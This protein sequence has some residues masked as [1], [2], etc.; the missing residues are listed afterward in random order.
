[1]K[2][3][4]MNHEKID[5]ELAIIQKRCKIRLIDAIDVRQNIL[6]IENKLTKLL[7]ESKWKG[8]K[9]IVDVH[10]QHFPNCY[11]GS[12]EST[13]F[14]LEYFS[15]WFITSID[16]THCNSVINRYRLILSREQ[17]LNMVDFIVKTF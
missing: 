15:N 3:N 11:G 13:Q 1:M 17:Q 9:I 5:S 6:V 14:T 4:A 7:P 2:I 16:R 10:A 12:P 8:I